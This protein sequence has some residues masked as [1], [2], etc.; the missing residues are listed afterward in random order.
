MNE[1]DNIQQELNSMGSSLAGL[2]RQIPY[3]VPAGY[4]N[5]LADNIVAK[6]RMQEDALPD[7]GRQMP[8]E[9]PADYFAALPEMVLEMAKADG[10]AGVKKPQTI[11]F[12]PRLRW[13][14]AAVLAI[15]IGVGTVMVFSTH[16]QT[17]S[18]SLLAAVPKNEISA[19]IKHSYGFDAARVVNSNQFNNLNVD[20]KD[21][22]A[23]LNETGWD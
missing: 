15:V 2:P 17:A 20:Y 9:V 14:A 21:I 3:A 19:Y 4:F 11:L 10:Q 12:V 5:Q 8:Y 13:A 23:Y 18:D 16:T 7:F 22:E 6:A 1:A